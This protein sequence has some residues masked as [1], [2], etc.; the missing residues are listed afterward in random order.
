MLS[1]PG[2]EAVS[3]AAFGLYFHNGSY[4]TGQEAD[5]GCCLLLSLSIPFTHLVM[6]EVTTVWVKGLIRPTVTQAKIAL[7]T[8]FRKPS[9]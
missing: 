1:C 9:L 2:K 8:W 6:G 7:V 4:S 5:V 3:G